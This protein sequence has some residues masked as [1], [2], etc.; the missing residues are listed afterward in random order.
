MAKTEL[1]RIAVVETQMQTVLENQKRQDARLERIEAAV[2][3]VTGGWK[4][5]AAIAGLGATIGAALVSW[6]A[7]FKGA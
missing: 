7:F 1:E 6:L 5:I 4:I 2:T 3:S